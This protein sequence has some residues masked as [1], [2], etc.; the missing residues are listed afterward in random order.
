MVGP[1]P[2]EGKAI[3]FVDLT[4]AYSLRLR[5]LAQE[6]DPTLPNGV[7]A[8]LLGGA[9]ETPAEIKMFAKMGADLVGMSTV[10]ETIAARHL[11]VEVLGISLV[12]NQAAGMS[13]ENLD[14]E[15]VL[16]AAEDAGPRMMSLLAGILERL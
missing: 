7:Y 10:L 14:H 3:R 1:A 9:F 15:D 13:E 6:V 11:G 2:P 16:A 8:G 12:T 5:R 4:E